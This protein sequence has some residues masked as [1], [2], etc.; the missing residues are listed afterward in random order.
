MSHNSGT[1]VT[2]RCGG[3]PV[4]AESRGGKDS[5]AQ[6]LLSTF[7]VA[8][9][10]AMHVYKHS[11]DWNRGLIIFDLMLDTLLAGMV[12]ALAYSWLRCRRQG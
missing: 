1:V 9:L 7:Q 5:L 8:A 4:V 2:W 6:M 11:R 10:L 12:G 3:F